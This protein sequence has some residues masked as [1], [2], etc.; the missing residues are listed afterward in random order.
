MT[1]PAKDNFGR[2]TY[3]LV[4]GTLAF[5]L[6][7]MAL[8]G[9]KVMAIS[10]S[11]SWHDMEHLL[12]EQEHGNA[13][14]EITLPDDSIPSILPVSMENAWVS[15]EFGLRKKHPV[16]GRKN[17]QHSGIDLAVW[18]GT[19]VKATAEGVVTYAGS[20]GGYGLLVEIDHLNGFVTR[21]AHNDSIKVKKGQYLTKGTVVALSGNSGIST[22][23]H[24]H[25]EVRI[26]GK[27][28]N[29]RQYLPGL[30][31]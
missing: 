2:L 23:A 13:E 10:S 8:M 5:A 27:A 29:P 4:V 3:M 19:P 6:A 25:Y 30:P 14:H 16:T 31:E 11:G 22:G 28:V 18:L 21:Y 15:S 9:P 17:V 1:Q 26:S 20:K 7:M 24:L 12:P